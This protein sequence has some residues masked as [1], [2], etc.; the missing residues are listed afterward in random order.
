MPRSASLSAS[1]SL[2]PSP[3]IATVCP[4]ACRALTIACF[5]CGLTRPN[6]ERSSSRAPSA[7]GSSGRS[8]ASTG[9][10]AWG[11]PA[12]AATALTVSGLSPEITFSATPWAAKYAMASAASDLS[13]SANTTN[14]AGRRPGGQR[15]TVQGPRGPGQHQ[16]PAAA[17]GEPAACDRYSCWPPGEH[18]LRRAQHPGAVPGEAGRAPLARRRERHRVP[19]APTRRRR[20]DLPDGGQRRVLVLLTGERAERRLGRRLIVER[21]EG[22]ERDGPVGQGA[23][24]VEAHHVD[25]GQ[26]LD[27]G[28]LLHQHPAAGQGDRGHAERD[29]GQQHQ[30]LRDHADQRGDRRRSARPA[31]S[32]AH[33]AG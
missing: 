23:G 4:R 3:V 21:D 32:R 2:T 16:D 13:R 11:R 20:E 9:S 12:R 15:L 8:R 26:A 6:T 18:H 33:A 29:A 10:P 28:K 25:P 1:T 22:V 27:G 19:G 17:S 5:W 31:P 7:A 24:L 14:A 30:A